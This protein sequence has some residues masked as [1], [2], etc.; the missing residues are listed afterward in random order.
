MPAL[1]TS[2][3]LDSTSAA[4]TSLRM[5][6][7]SASG[8]PGFWSGEAPS[9]GDHSFGSKVA[10]PPRPARDGYEWVWFPDGY[11]AER[12]SERKSSNDSQA[13]DTTPSAVR[14]S[15]L[16]RWGSKPSKGSK[17]LPDVTLEHHDSMRSSAGVSPLSEVQHSFWQ[18]P[19][20][21]PQ[22]PYLSEQQ[23]IAALQQSNPL[24]IGGSQLR[25]TWKSIDAG[26][27]APTPE[28]LTPVSR[29]S[30]ASAGSRLSWRPFQKQSVSIAC[31]EAHVDNLLNSTSWQTQ[32][33]K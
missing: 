21:L 10:D 31:H 20:D 2:R 27:S 18:L 22:S 24:Q 28:V 16:F 11:W 29:H 6:T 5:S 17:D 33:V 32:Q 13:S 4:S 12:P 3:Q 9:L 25:D 14:P 23:Q 7:N 30:T 8:S 15:K 19:K 26:A 1:N